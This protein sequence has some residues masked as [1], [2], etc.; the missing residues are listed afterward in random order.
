MNHKILSCR[1]MTGLLIPRS[2]R[3]ATSPIVRISISPR[4]Q[5]DQA[6]QHVFE[7]RKPVSRFGQIFGM[8][9]KWKIPRNLAAASTPPESLD[10]EFRPTTLVQD[11]RSGK[12][13]AMR[14]VPKSRQR[15]LRPYRS[16]WPGALR[17]RASF[18]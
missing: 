3:A 18:R 10:A 1:G 6:V 12:G 14:N 9:A 17:R 15:L 8:Q 4:R 16:G 13:R 7:H 2:M 11:F 5:V